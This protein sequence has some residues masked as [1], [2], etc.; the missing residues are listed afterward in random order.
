MFDIFPLLALSTLIVLYR[1][2]RMEENHR[3]LNATFV[4]LKDQ[5]AEVMTRMDAKDR[6]NATLDTFYQSAKAEVD[7]ILVDQLGASPALDVQPPNPV[8]RAWSIQRL[9]Y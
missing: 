6:E 3:N 2:Y 4:E 5:L 1:Q 9:G 8:R 7:E